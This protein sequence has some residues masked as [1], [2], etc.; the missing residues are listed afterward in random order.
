M[1]FWIPWIIDLAFAIVF[2]CFFV[3]GLGDGSVSSSN[4]LL[5]LI[6]L[7]TAAVLLGGSFMLKSNGHSVL[8]TVM[9]MIPALP[10]LLAGILFLLMIILKPKWN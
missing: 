1:L 2:V 10:G 9:V 6:I 8:A 3:I 7:G 5:W 4:L